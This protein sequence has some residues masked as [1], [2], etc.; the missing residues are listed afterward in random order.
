MG[1][2]VP[3]FDPA[4]NQ[5][6]PVFFGGDSTLPS[7]SSGSARSGKELVF[8]FSYVFCLVFA[9][10]AFG[11]LLPFCC[12]FPVYVCVCSLDSIPLSFGVHSAPTSSAKN[13]PV[14]FS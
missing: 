4:Q 7:L 6:Q 11:P 3:F 1:S 13:R 5:K 2:T 8:G 9:F 10:C 14:L 12:F